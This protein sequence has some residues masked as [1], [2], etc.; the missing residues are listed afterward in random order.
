MGPAKA[1]GVKGVGSGQSRVVKVR[2]AI[3]WGGKPPGRPE[4]GWPESQEPQESK[5]FVLRT[6]INGGMG[7]KK[8]TY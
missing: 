5:S 2:A 1:R 7:V 4:A 3:G 8:V 6:Y